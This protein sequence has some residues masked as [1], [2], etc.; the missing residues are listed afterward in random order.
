[1]GWVDA[2]KGPIDVLWEGGSVCMSGG[3]GSIPR[4]KDGMGESSGNGRGVGEGMS[5]PGHGC[6]VSEGMLGVGDGCGVGEGMVGQG[7]GC[8]VDEEGS[9][10]G[11]T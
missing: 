8:G 2:R 5:N 10:V 11:T 9:R 3:V 1:M 6:G 7:D 4:S